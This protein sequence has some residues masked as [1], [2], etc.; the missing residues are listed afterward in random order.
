MNPFKYIARLFKFLRYWW[1]GNLLEVK[2]QD[3]TSDI[4]SEAQRAVDNVVFETDI[5]PDCVY[6]TVINGG[7]AIVVKHNAATEVCVHN[8][9]A[10]AALEAIKWLQAREGEIHTGKVSDLNREQR[11]SFDAQR[12]ARRRH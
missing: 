12:K 4:R 10:E 9:Y 2:L 7:C 8:S 5:A 1:S 6:A 11:R 3:K